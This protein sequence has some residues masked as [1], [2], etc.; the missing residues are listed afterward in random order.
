MKC[1]LS[2]AQILLGVLLIL[3]MQAIAAPLAGRDF[4]P[5]TPVQPVETGDK[6]EVLEAFSYAC[7][8]CHQFEPR[9]TS[10]AR[11]LPA[12]VVVRKMPVTFGRDAWANLARAYYALEAMGEL[13]KLHGKMFE[14]IHSQNIQLT[15]P[16][17]LSDWVAKQ[18]I[19]RKKFADT[20][21]SF[22]VQSKVGRLAQ[23]TRSYGID[24]VPTIIVD[25][26]YRVTG[27]NNYEELFRITNELIQL[28][29]TQRPV[30]TAE[31]AKPNSP[32]K[33]VTAK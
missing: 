8:H 7:S 4:T 30:K 32:K 3:A 23:L 19:D 15:D 22:A 21:Q 13:G 29:R 33:P 9:L 25:G 10:W 5:V 1:L 28:A 11:T 6:I 12:D 18:G 20:Y 27:G 2:R 17:V 16:Q 31:M 24:S 26:K 14:A